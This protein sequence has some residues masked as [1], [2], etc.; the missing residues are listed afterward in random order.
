MFELDFGWCAPPAIAQ[1]DGVRA[2]EVLV[3]GVFELVECGAFGGGI[4]DGSD[5]MLAFERSV[6][7][8]ECGG[9]LGGRPRLTVSGGVEGSAGVAGAARRVCSW[10]V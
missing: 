7:F 3:G 10:A 2:C 4:R 1:V 5:D 8:G 9:D 6:G